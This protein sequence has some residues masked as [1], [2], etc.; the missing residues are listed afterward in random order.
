MCSGYLN[1]QQIIYFYFVFTDRDS[2][3]LTDI[4]YT[5]CADRVQDYNAEFN[6]CNYELQRYLEKIPKGNN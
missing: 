6:N 4:Q 5:K 3:N 2:V 1:K